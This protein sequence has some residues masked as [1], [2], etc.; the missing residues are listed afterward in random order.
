[1]FSHLRARMWAGA[2]VSAAGAPTVYYAQR[3]AA[4]AGLMRSGRLG[5][6]G[7]RARQPLS[8]SPSGRAIVPQGGSSY[9][10]RMSSLTES[11]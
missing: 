11:E 5:M 6:K 4:T 7:C 10:A 2:R 1:M 3:A 9:A 8:L